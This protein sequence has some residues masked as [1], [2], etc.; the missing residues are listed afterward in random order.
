MLLNAWLSCLLSLPAAAVSQADFALGFVATPAG[1]YCD[2]QCFSQGLTAS[3]FKKIGTTLNTYACAVSDPSLGGV[4]SGYQFSNGSATC[5]VAST[6]ATDNST[7]YDC[8]CQ[9]RTAKCR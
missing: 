5:S 3:Q 8:L 9:V 6:M 7:E 2:A 1:T 4:I